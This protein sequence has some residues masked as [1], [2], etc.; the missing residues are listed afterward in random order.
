MNLSLDTVDDD[1]DAYVRLFVLL[2]ADDT[3]LFSETK[4]G[5]QQSLDVF[6]KYC[7]DW[8]LEVNVKKTKVMIFNSNRRTQFVFKF[9]DFCMYIVDSFRYLGI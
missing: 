8:K 1:L 9:G 6:K 5:L 3:I 7:I 4:K 2:Y